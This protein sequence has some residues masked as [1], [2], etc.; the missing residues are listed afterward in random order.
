MK[1]EGSCY[2]RSVCYSVESRTPYPYMRC[3]CSFCRKGAGSGGYA[4][5][6]M[7]DSDTLQVQGESNL[8]YHHGLEHDKTSDDLVKNENRRYFCK[9][10]GSALWSA[11]PRWAQ[12]IYPFASSVNSPLPK[13][14][15]V[16][17]IMLDFAVD[18]LDVPTG[19]GHRHFRRYPDESIFDW[20]KRHNLLQN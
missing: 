3:Y 11:D 1:L 5:N 14:P 20:H 4:I 9:Q 10:C 18:W 2:C 17:H 16:F 15:E 19:K 6:I 13:P 8:V 7:A 12:W